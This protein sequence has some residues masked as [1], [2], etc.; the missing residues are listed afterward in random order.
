MNKNILS[1]TDSKDKSINPPVLFSKKVNINQLQIK[2]TQKK[3]KV[4]EVFYF[5][6]SSSVT[7]YTYVTISDE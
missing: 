3:Q 1:K 7:Y 4:Y 2:K 6:H 5:F